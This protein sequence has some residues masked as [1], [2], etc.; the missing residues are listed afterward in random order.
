MHWLRGVAVFTKLVHMLRGLSGCLIS[1]QARSELDGPTEAEIYALEHLSKRGC[2]SAPTLLAWKHGVQA[3]H[4]WVPGGYVVY[5]LMNK[6]PG[7]PVDNIAGLPR[8]ERDSLRKA[9]KE[10][11]M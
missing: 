3:E 4:Q 1:K 9:F 7:V 5:I 10:S 11:W 6:L 8:D 2:S